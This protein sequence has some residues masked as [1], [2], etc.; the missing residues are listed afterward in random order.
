MRKIWI[1]IVKLFGWKF[2]TPDPEKARQIRHC[3]LIEAPHTSIYD[4]FLGASC[5][6]ELGVDGRF[7]IKK[8]FFKFPIRG[9]LR[10]CGALPID[11]GNRNNHLVDSAVRQLK[12]NSS[13][14]IIIT[15]E[16][17]RKLTKR[18][19][20]GFYEI[21]MQA[22]VPI[23][24]CYIDYRRKVMSIGPMLVPSGDF[25]A[26][27]LKILEIYNDITPRNKSGWNLE[28]L[29]ETYRKEVQKKR[30]GDKE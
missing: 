20:R 26:D 4:F 23:A 25:A 7:F 22:S 15:P 12:D 28:T 17:T 2:E 11:R 9:F 1:G 13:M 27:M 29:K 6:W 30:G 14:T 10:R 5:V 3:V 8:E 16:G 18:W 21:A 24:V 19:K